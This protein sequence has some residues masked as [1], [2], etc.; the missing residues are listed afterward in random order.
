M[1]EHYSNDDFG[2]RCYDVEREDREHRR[3][4]TKYTVIGITVV[5]LV[6]AL[7]GGLGFLLFRGKGGPK[8]PDLIGR[9]YTQ[10][11]STASAAQFGI[12]IDE[13]Q[14][15]SLPHSSLKVME[16]SPKAG[17]E[18]EKGEIITVRLKG[19]AE[20]EQALGDG[21]VNKTDSPVG[22]ETGGQAAPGSA[23]NTAVPSGS[24]ITIC[25]DPG[26]ST[27]CP[28]S[29]I[30]PATGLNVADNSGASGE[31]ETNW[32]IAVRTKV[33][34]E[35]AGYTVKLTKSQ[36][37]MY[38]SLRT[39]ADIGNTCTVAVRIHFDP[40][41]HALLYPAEGQYKKNGGS[42]KY[43]EPSVAAASA[44]LAEAMFPYLQNAGISS[45]RNDCGG[46]SGNTGSAFV[47]SVL[48]T[49]PVVL[50][51]NNPNIV[52]ANPAGQETV[53]DAILHGLNAYFGR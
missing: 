16:Q 43:V 45:K 31:L 48:S 42:V 38:S 19:L 14:D 27:G 39:R 29:E 34:L 30:D 5:I 22:L 18:G 6:C 2:N 47:G 41:L 51:E 21:K 33:K 36:P 53:A 24:G 44:K 32:E 17:S 7:I 46:T 25:L 3:H 9:T 28:A 1:A 35:Q 37:D 50:I 49:V 13:T 20:A 4:V 12:E 10:A 40:E 52:K 23:G 8:V 26:H 15:S 11:K